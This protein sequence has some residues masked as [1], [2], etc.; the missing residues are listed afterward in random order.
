MPI[1]G[2]AFDFSKMLS[3]FYQLNT[4]KPYALPKL[5]TEIEKLEGKFEAFALSEVPGEG[6]VI[7]PQLAL[8]DAATI[9]EPLPNDEPYPS[10]M[11]VGTKDFEEEKQDNKVRCFDKNGK[12]T[13][14]SFPNIIKTYKIL[15]HLVKG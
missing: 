1:D 8:S 6:Y 15:Q 14:G 5:I 2:T 9:L 12:K 11:H 4:Y 3:S 7:Y 10:L 13:V